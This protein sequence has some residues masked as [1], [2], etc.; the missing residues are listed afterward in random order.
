MLWRYGT[1][2]AGVRLDSER[3][4]VLGEPGRVPAASEAVKR[5]LHFYGPAT[6]GDFA[7]WAVVAKPH[8][9]RLWEAIEA[10]LSEV[11][12]GKRK[13]FLLREDAGEL[14]SPQ[15]AK[16]TRL[17]PPR[18]LKASAA[19]TA[20]AASEASSIPSLSGIG[21]EGFTVQLRSAI[22]GRPKAR[23]WAIS[24]SVPHSPPTAI[25]A[26]AEA[27]TARFRALPVAAATTCVQWGWHRRAR[28][29]P[30]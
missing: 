19:A 23:A 13:S 18:R 7:E 10:G 28:D 26:S 16:G 5:F 12:V 9:K 6:P 2:K 27:T 3:R 29:R 30:S 4:Y 21:A 20:P 14:H 17:I 22:T 11:P 8:A 15:Q 25:T 24:E 1:V